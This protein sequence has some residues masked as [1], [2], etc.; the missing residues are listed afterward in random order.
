M[1]VRT[2]QAWRFSSVGVLDLSPYLLGATVIDADSHEI[3]ERSSDLDQI[4]AG[5][6]SLTINFWSAICSRRNSSQAGV[7]FSRSSGR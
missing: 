4:S 2:D 6:F 5:W 7:L 3:L 1:P